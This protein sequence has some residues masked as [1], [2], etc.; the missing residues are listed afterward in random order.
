MPAQMSVKGTAVEVATDKA[1][2]VIETVATSGSI[3]G[4]LAV[5]TQYLQFG[6]AVFALLVAIST[7]IY[8]IYWK[9][10][11]ELRK[12]E[13]LERESLAT[14]E[15]NKQI[16]RHNDERLDVLVDRRAPMTEEQILKMLRENFELQEKVKI[17]LNKTNGEK[18]NE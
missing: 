3:A 2:V 5:Y 14:I 16:A 12:I 13:I 15:L 18:Y 7:F 4:G 8:W 10:K 9:P 17:E 1:K 6:G 11:T